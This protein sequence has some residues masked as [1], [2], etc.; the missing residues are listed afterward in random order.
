[1]RVALSDL[2]GQERKAKEEL[3]KALDRQKHMDRLESDAKLALD[4]YAACASLGLENL[5][6]EERRDVYRR[7]HL[8]VTV[9]PSGAL[10]VEGK[11]DANWLPEAGKIDEAALEEARKLDQA[12][13]ALQMDNNGS[14][15]I[16]LTI[17]PP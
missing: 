12:I 10:V 8:L 7:L 5:T 11:P 13:Q 2:E 15:F 1:L 6:P 4:Y 17:E 14:P 9:K 3:D 16:L